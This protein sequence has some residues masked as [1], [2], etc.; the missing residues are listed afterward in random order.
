VQRVNVEIIA[1]SETCTEF[2]NIHSVSDG[3]IN[4]NTTVIITEVV[5]EN[6]LASCCSLC[7]IEFRQ[8]AKLF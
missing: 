2:F 8:L 7:V 5:T 3:K 6:G 1:I 4:Q